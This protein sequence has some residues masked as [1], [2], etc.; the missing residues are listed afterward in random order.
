MGDVVQ[1]KFGSIACTET[2]LHQLREELRKWELRMKETG[3][4]DVGDIVKYQ[5]NFKLLNLCR[6]D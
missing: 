1:R 4:N 2:R 3:K 6:L 5:V